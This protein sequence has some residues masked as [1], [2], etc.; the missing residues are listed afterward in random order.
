MTEFQAALLSAQLTRLE[1][2]KRK[3]AE[4]AAYL[5][6]KLSQIEGIS[7]LRQDPDQNCYSYIFKYDGRH[8]QDVSVWRLRAAVAAEGIPC[9]SSASHQ[10]PVYRSPVFVPAQD[11]QRRELPC[12]KEG[13]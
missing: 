7:T 4:N 11:L 13:L 6:E 8:F 3:R 2:H 10:F 1:E 9:F 12:R 5:K